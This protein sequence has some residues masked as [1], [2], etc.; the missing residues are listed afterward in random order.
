MDATVSPIALT[1]QTQTASAGASSSSA[2][3]QPQ[4]E[5]AQMQQPMD[6]QNVASNPSTPGNN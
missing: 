6:T 5:G 2:A 1:N 3:S 4:Q